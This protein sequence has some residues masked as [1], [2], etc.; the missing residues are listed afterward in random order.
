GVMTSPALINERSTWVS[1][2]KCTTMSASLTS[3]P[4]TSGSA[5]PPRTKVW[6]GFPARSP[7]GFGP[8]R[9]GQLVEGDDSPLGVPLQGIPD[10]VG[11]DEPGAARDDDITHACFHSLS[12]CSRTRACLAAAR[13]ANTSLPRHSGKREHEPA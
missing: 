9:G 4:A 13:S 11:S 12:L 2:A 3:G 1:A 8:G 7:G 10:E 5:T 6:R